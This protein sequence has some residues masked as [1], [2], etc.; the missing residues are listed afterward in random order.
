MLCFIDHDNEEKIYLP[1]LK[2]NGATIPE[3]KIAKDHGDLM[4]ELAKLEDIATQLVDGTSN[5]QTFIQ[6]LQ[7]LVPA[8]VQDMKEHLQEE[9]TVFPRIIRDAEI[10]LELH[11]QTV[12]AIIQA[13]GLEALQTELPGILVAMQDW[14][15]PEFYADFLAHELPPPIKELALNVLIPNYVNIHC[16]LRDSPTMKSP[17][18]MN[19]VPFDPSMLPPPPPADQ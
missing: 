10:P 12:G 18:P 11:Q 8:F 2:D 4:T 7:S 14:G 15:T 16:A 6:D 19:E 1:M 13:G 5:A 3:D 9:E 17:P